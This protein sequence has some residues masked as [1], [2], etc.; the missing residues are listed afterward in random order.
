MAVTTSQSPFARPKNWLIRKLDRWAARWVLRAMVEKTENMMSVRWTG[1]QIWQ[2]PVDAWVVQEVIS[3]LKPDLIIETGTFLGGSAYYYGCICDMLGHGHVVSVDIAPKGIQPHPRVTY[4][5]GSSVAPEI[6]DQVADLARSLQA[7]QILVILDSDH[8][9]GHVLQEMEIYSAFVPMG[10]YMMVQDACIDEYEVF[11]VDRPG[12]GVAI[13]KFLAE[14]SDLVLD[15][16]VENR[17]VVTF[18]PQGWLKRVAPDPKPIDLTPPAEQTPVAAPKLNV[19]DIYQ[20]V[21]F[22]LPTHR[23]SEIFPG[24]EGVSVRSI[25]SQI[26]RKDDWPLPVVELLTLGAICQHLQPKRIFEIGTYRGASTVMMGLNTPEETEIFTLD[27][28]PETQATHQHGLG[29]GLPQFPVGEQFQHNPTV[30]PKIT[31]LYGDS[32]EFDFSPYY[33]TL[34][35]VVID[36]DHTY[37][38]VKSDTVQALKLLR[39]GGVILWDDYLW[40]QKY[41]ECAGV[42]RCLDELQ[43]EIDCVQIAETRLAIYVS[44]QS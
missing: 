36:A 1:R 32:R 22:Q 8:S 9:A 38:F 6:V 20:H 33:G 28:L 17:Y 19:P 23:L 16:E 18:H 14:R 42:T 3:E 26:Q 30:S 31:Q 40:I 25:A 24:I 41:P 34:D 7:K 2:C 4:I 12:P 10:G 35:L 39:P 15:R 29:V 43:Q 27:L 5:S 13:Q 11:K 37:E 21:N 44:P